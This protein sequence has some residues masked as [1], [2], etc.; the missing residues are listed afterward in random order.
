M[1]SS[2][3]ETRYLRYCI[4][5]CHYILIGIVLNY[6]LEIKLLKF[7]RHKFEQKHRVSVERVVSGVGVATVYEFL[8][9]EFPAKVDSIIHEKVTCA[10]AC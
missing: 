2:L 1:L 9:E 8:C 7:L 6:K 4:I 5:D 3:L 10:C